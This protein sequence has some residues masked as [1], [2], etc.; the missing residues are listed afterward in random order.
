MAVMTT[1]M[2]MV[3]AAAA[4]A[5][6]SVTD[7]N[8]CAVAAGRGDLDRSRITAGRGFHDGG[9][10]AASSSRSVG[11]R[12]TAVATVMAVMTASMATPERVGVA[13]EREQTD[14]REAANESR[15]PSIPHEHE[16]RCERCVGAEALKIAA[17]L[18]PGKRFAA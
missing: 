16:L 10:L 12:V 5:L 14:D 8:R 2:A 11:H 18:D 17:L 15:L 1:M 6:R 9:R 7:V 13:S 3:T 4:S